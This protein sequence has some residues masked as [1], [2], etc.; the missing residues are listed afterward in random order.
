MN[1]FVL[2]LATLFA[3]AVPSRGRAAIEPF[4][5]V[6]LAPADQAVALQ[7]LPAGE[8]VLHDERRLGVPTF[9]WAAF[10]PQQ[11]PPAGSAE[12]IAW[13]HVRR[14]AA[15]YRLDD[16]ALAQLRLESLH[17]TG[18]GAIVA[19]YVRSIDGVD[20]FKD[21][22]R[23]VLDRK[24][25]LVAITG[26]VPGA[27]PI[28]TTYAMEPAEALARAAAELGETLS[29]RDFVEAGADEGGF[30]RF[31][32]PGLER[33]ARVRPVWFH[34][35]GVLFPAWHVE[36][37]TPAG[38]GAWVFD[39]LERRVLW[40]RDLVQDASYRVWADPAAGDLPFDGP[41]GTA[42]SPHPTSLP[43][44][45][46][47]ATT[48]PAR[49]DIDA[50]PISTRDPWLAPD[51]TETVGNNVD[52][53]TDLAPPDGRALNDR[54]GAVTAPGTF[55]R[56]YD[57]R[58]GPTA[59][60]D[61][62]MAA[63]TQL[64]YVTNWLHDWFY[65]A[66]F[67]EAAG[68]AQQDNLGRGGA[69][70]D[71]LFAEAQDYAGLNNANMGTPADG[72]N[73]RMQMFVFLANFER[74]VSVVAPESAAT[75]YG[76]G[77]AGFGPQEF[78]VTG[79][80]VVYDDGVGATSDGCQAPVNDL[81]GK[82]ALIDRGTCPFSEKTKRAQDAGA[83][84]VIIANNEAGF[85]PGMGGEETGVTIGVL[86]VSQNDGN[87]LRASAGVTVQLFREL[88]I[89]R[90]SALD[91]TVVAHEFTHMVSSRLVGNA[92]GLGNNQGGGLGEGWSDFAS[93]L[94][95]ARAEDAQVPGNADFGGTY[96]IGA[97]VSSGGGN[98]GYYYGMRRYPYS[99]DF[100]RNPLTFRH[101]END[102]QLPAT[103]P[104]AFGRSGRINAE[105]HRTGEVWAEMLW[106]CYVALL[107]DGERFAFAE[108]R[109]HMLELLVAS[110]KITPND[111]TLLEARD[112]LLAA[113]WASDPR[114]YAL[115]L[116][117]FAR[118]GAGL[119]AQGPDRWSQDHKTVTESFDDGYDIELAGARI[120]DAQ[121]GCDRDGILDAGETGR[122]VL[123]LRNRGIGAL[124]ATSARVRIATPG[125]TVVG[126][127]TVSV[128]ATQPLQ[129]V[130]I[131]VPVQADGLSAQ[132]P[133]EVEVELSD[134]ALD[135]PRTFTWGASAHYDERPATS[136]SDDVESART[137]WT[138]TADE[139]LAAG[140]PWQRV[141]V[142]GE[143]FR[144][145]GPAVGT[146]ADLALVSPPL[147]VGDGPLR[148]RFRHRH[149]FEV[150]DGAN[151]DGG[152]VE[153]SADGRVWTRVD[154]GYGGAIARGFGSPLAGE[155]AFVGDS[156]GWPAMTDATVDFGTAWAGQS[157]RV[158]FRV[159]SDLAFGGPGWEIDDIAFEGLANRP[160]PSVVPEN[161]SCENL[162]P[163]AVI[164]GSRSGFERSEL[165]IDGSASYDPDW[166]ELTYA[167][168][169]VD[170]P[171]VEWVDDASPVG[172]FLAPDVPGNT[173]VVLRLE[174]SDGSLSNSTTATFVIRESNRPPV[175]VARGP[176]FAT[177]RTEVVL[178]GSGSS[179]PDE[180]TRLTY[181]WAQ[182]DGPSVV[183]LEP[184][185]AAPH[186]TAP[187]VDAETPVR[188]SL[189]VSDGLLE[190]DVAQVEVRIVPDDQPPVATVQGPLEVEEGG[191]V[192]LVGSATDR[193]E[194]P[195]TFRW[196]QVAG[197]VGVLENADAAEATL[198][199]PQ[200]ARDEVLTFELVAN[201]GVNDSAPAV[202]EVTVRNRLERESDTDSGSGCGCT[203]GGPAA[204]L[205]LGAWAVVAGFL[206][207]RRP[208]T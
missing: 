117:A 125:V 24:G 10:A 56:S 18:R 92:A 5:A 14:H 8:L 25:G 193:E 51:A 119:H 48:A 118:R 12:Q 79:E 82:V 176:A 87:A 204:A 19:T 115:F 77:V 62:S 148:M 203:S 105:S 188:F 167:W 74:R 72:D 170:G 17:D 197:P 146:R 27:R 206:R 145:H 191:R 120:D 139:S 192:A 168:S 63:A 150:R 9:V 114:D 182:V 95:L 94:F 144:W 180:G 50:G 166:N 155:D 34:L 93:L 88:A 80:L 33:E 107:R 16:A 201:D 128:P 36:L 103:A 184:R 60:A 90:D 126:T 208:R 75:S 133:F 57:L 161:G 22:L 55:D 37:E 108:A 26:F 96:A 100:A 130:E 142:P 6:S 13:S 134:P 38:H 61:Q 81:A 84:G 43:D 1:R 152:V 185:S 123:Q 198:V 140:I 138:P 157:V 42:G 132:T 106:E 29:S 30:A 165:S 97:W 71:R 7:A 207:R 159:G 23:V 47:A 99:V 121:A 137:T 70:R 153:I 53:Y 160:F 131:S 113:A 66:G 181:A 54:R 31:A 110:F 68:N 85:A 183:L 65:D 162:P 116:R 154:A 135:A 190:S 172:R 104:L 149:S 205:E 101:I 200:V 83:V 58:L 35:P 39:A 46:Q 164:S 127:E 86:S 91:T 151:A 124:S 102:V 52:A 199:A 67:D 2:A 32:A 78:D 179:D 111:P 196:T 98:A 187:A 202:L 49:V 4:D 186:F 64:F 156:A 141:F 109:Q 45:F 169:Q 3:A 20:V 112:A 178:D 171:E 175:A 15:L 194:R 129:A 122:L 40:R 177:Q 173:E 163:V 28:S 158:R 21:R 143:G 189:R 136:A 73:P 41:Q 59:N 147:E 89:D 76:V 195:L 69:A 174:V 44:G 11:P